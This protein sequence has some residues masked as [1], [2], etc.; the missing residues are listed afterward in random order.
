MSGILSHSLLLPLLFYKTIGIDASTPTHLFTCTP[1]GTHG[2]AWAWAR[3]CACAWQD[4]HTKDD[5]SGFTFDEHIFPF[6]ADDMG[7]LNKKG[8]IVTLNLHDAS[9]VNHWDAKF[10]ALLEATG[11]DVAGAKKVAMNL[12]N[13][14]VAY[15]VEDIVLGDLV[16]S[17]GFF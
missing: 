5:W 15:A 12:V 17:H 6:P 9:G 16:V 7:Y 14:S 13:A 10:P 2:G 4:W 1:N 11:G 3:T 8:L